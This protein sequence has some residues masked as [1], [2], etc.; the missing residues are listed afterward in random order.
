M[1]QSR[2]VMAISNMDVMSWLIG[3]ILVPIKKN[4]VDLQG[5]WLD[6]ELEIKYSNSCYIFNHL[7]KNLVVAGPNILRVLRLVHDLDFRGKEEELSRLKME[8]LAS[9]KMFGWIQS[10][11]SVRLTGE[12]RDS[13]LL[14][15]KVLSIHK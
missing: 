9:L 2:K 8:C 5:H 4:R 10:M 12:E 7:E 11:T 1:K 6:I 14:T 13:L 3:D 15:F